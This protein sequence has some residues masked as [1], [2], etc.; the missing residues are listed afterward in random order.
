MLGSIGA[1]QRALPILNAYASL[2][3]SPACCPA[4]QQ[5]PA[6]LH[7]N[8]FQLPVLS[9]PSPLACCNL[10][11]CSLHPSAGF[12]ITE[13]DQFLPTLDKA[14]EMDCPVIIS[15]DVDYSHNK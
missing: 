6:F 10:F 14:L 12:H 7:S 2:C 13:A 4:P 1:L 3:S 9:S 15:V 8:P 5:L 11:A